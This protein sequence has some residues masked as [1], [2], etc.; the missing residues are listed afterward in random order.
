[1]ESKAGS[2][3]PGGVSIK[4]RLA[5]FAAACT[6]ALNRSGWVVSTAS[7]IVERIPDPKPPHA[8]RLC[9]GSASKRRTVRPRVMSS[10]PRFAQRLVFDTPPL[11]FKIARIATTT[12]PHSPSSRR[13]L[14]NKYLNFGKTAVFGF[15]GPLGHRNEG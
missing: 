13:S 11:R 9:W 1:A 4:T 12:P 8:L 6:F 15:Y 14:R 10:A 5:S 3:N 7:T 2:A